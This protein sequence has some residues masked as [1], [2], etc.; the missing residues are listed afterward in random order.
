MTVSPPGPKYHFATIA[1]GP[2]KYHFVG[3]CQSW[4]FSFLRN[5]AVF[6]VR[7]FFFW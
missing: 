3:I 2:T 5:A 7:R 6:S 4:I 1:R